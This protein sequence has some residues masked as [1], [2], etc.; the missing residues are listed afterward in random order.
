MQMYETTSEQS[1][2]TNAKI[3][4]ENITI[5]NFYMFLQSF[6]KQ[7]KWL[8]TAVQENDILCFQNLN[9]PES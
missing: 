9:P 6:S 3:R 4:N 8:H 2:V 1:H 7:S 5:A